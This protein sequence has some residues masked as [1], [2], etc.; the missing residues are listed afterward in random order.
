[1]TWLRLLFSTLVFL[2][3]AEAAMAQGEPFSVECPTGSYVTGF[4]GR[5]G[6]W[7]DRLSIVCAKWNANR[8]TLETPSRDGISRVGGPGIPG[9]AGQSAGGSEIEAQCPMGWAVGGGYSIDYTTGGQDGLLHHFDFNCVPVGEER[10][11]PQPLRFGSNSNSE[12][13]SRGASRFQCDEHQLASGISGRDGLFIDEFHLVCSAPGAIF[14]TKR[15]DPEIYRDTGVA[16]APRGSMK[17]VIVGDAGTTP[18]PPPPAPGKTAKV[19]LDVEV[20]DGPGG[21][22]NKIGDLAPDTIVGLVGCQADNWCH[23]NGGNVP[24]GDG[25]VYSGPDYQSLEL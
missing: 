4:V 3:T 20:Y 21:G 23:V 25:W 1:M 19:K 15:I 10:G 22:G 11:D 7:V 8:V 12:I 24:N 2:C 14:T 17:D 13:V 18:P 9:F 6:D 5:A 16:S